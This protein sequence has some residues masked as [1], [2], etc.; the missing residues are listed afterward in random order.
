[1]IAKHGLEDKTG[2]GGGGAEGGEGGRWGRRRGEEEEEEEEEEGGE[3]EEE[4]S[5]L[6]GS[7]PDTNH[8]RWKKSTLTPPNFIHR[9]EISADGL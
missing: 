9:W 5:R 6:K 7:V 2:G 8:Y 3:E 1:M 4:T